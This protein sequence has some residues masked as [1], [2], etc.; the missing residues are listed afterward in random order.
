VRAQNQF[1]STVVLPCH[2]WSDMELYS[3]GFFSSTVLEI[4]ASLSLEA[5]ID[6]RIVENGTSSMSRNDSERGETNGK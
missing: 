6:R 2:S 1:E 5:M 4:E 3:S